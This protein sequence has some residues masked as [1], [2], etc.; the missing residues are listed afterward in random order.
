MEKIEWKVGDWCFCEYKLQQI[1]RVDEDG[2]VHEV[3]DGNFSHGG[4]LTDRCYPM[5]MK[6]KL[7]SEHVSYWREK[8]HKLNH[9]SLNMPDINRAL[10][11]RWCM[12]CDDR[13]DEKMSIKH[14]EELNEFCEKIV[15]RVSEAKDETV[16]GVKLF[17]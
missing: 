8:F 2:T 4:H 15:T 5:D 9:N 10:I 13:E 17:R 1:K 3:S 12:M 6:V 14:G 7:I 11:A 16:E